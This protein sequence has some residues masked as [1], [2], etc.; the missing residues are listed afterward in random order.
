MVKRSRDPCF[1]MRFKN[2]IMIPPVLISTNNNRVKKRTLEIVSNL[3]TL[4]SLIVILSVTFQGY[5]YA[6]NERNIVL[7]VA[8]DPDLPSIYLI[9]DSTVRNGA[10]DGANGQ[11]GWGSYL[12]E[13]FD[14]GKVNVVNRA[15]GARSTRTYI[16]Q[17]YWDQQ[18]VLLKQGDVVLIQFGHNDA[19]PVND[20]RRAR[21]VLD[22]TGDESEDIVNQLTGKDETVFSYGEYLRRYIADIRAAGAIPVICSPIP[23]NG[24]VISKLPMYDNWAERVALTE[25]TAFLDLYDIISN[26]YESLSQQGINDLFVEDRVHTNKQGARFNAR[27]VVSALKGLDQNPVKSWMNKEANAVQARS[28]GTEDPGY[29]VIAGYGVGTFVVDELIYHNDMG[30][31]SDWVLQLEQTESAYE[32]RIDHFNGYLEVL[33]PG[34]GATIWNK[35]K[36]TGNI[37]I[38]YKVKAPSTFVDGLGVVVRDVNTFWHASHP[39]YPAGIF[40]SDIYTGA[41]TSYHTM[42]GY[43]A[44]MGG[45]D[46]TT[47][48][49][50]RYPRVENGSDAD[51]IALSDKDG[52]KA[53]LITPDRTHRIQVVIFEDIVQYLVDGKVFYE[54]KEGDS[55]MEITEDGTEVETTYNTNEYPS[56]KEGWFGFRLVNT[57]H[58]FSE[59]NVY[60]LAPADQ[61]NP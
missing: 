33:V 28:A 32:P 60:R 44:S 30:S 55:V 53:Y 29:P 56:Y 3:N 6:Q 45:R 14:L 21:G 9:G 37:A 47:T 22:G 17:G 2:T 35:N 40:N 38:T 46:N 58:L 18:K 4:L 11:W 49:F 51:H 39:G 23:T 31:D 10:G 36:F 54:L 57:H 42:Q 13:F 15:I 1:K 43:Y 50:R 16:S 48:R 12:H 24:T 5:S 41:F 34:R 26:E 20:N 8:D 27:I 25:G 59:F 19:S 52:S 7:P 61:K